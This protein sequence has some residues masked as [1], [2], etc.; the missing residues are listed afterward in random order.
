MRPQSGL[1]HGWK[2]ACIAREARS[3]EGSVPLGYLLAVDSDLLFWEQP[4]P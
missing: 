1:L 4:P 3:C 2:L